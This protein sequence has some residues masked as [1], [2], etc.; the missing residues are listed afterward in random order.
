[1]RE[2]T[3]WF[4]ALI[5]VPGGLFSQGGLGFTE[6]LS[7]EVT[8]K[9]VGLRSKGGIFSRFSLPMFPTLKQKARRRLLPKFWKLRKVFLDYAMVWLFGGLGRNGQGDSF[10]G[11]CSFIEPHWLMMDSLFLRQ[12]T[13]RSGCSA[14]PPDFGVPFSLSAKRWIAQLKAPRTNSGGNSLSPYD[15]AWLFSLL[16]KPSPALGAIPGETESLGTHGL[17]WAAKGRPA[18]DKD[19][20]LFWKWMLNNMLFHSAP[21]TWESDDGTSGVGTMRRLPAFLCTGRPGGSRG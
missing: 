4:L 15:C 6:L 13:E 14:R 8:P 20:G 3:L 16:I 17:Q 1:M 9:G 5:C 19:S 21:I 2:H 7:N 11:G 18:T 12:E 10:W